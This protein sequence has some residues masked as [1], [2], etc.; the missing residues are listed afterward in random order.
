MAKDKKKL[1][2]T[3]RPEEGSSHEFRQSSTEEDNSRVA[4]SFP[5]TPENATERTGRRSAQT[6]SDIH[7]RAEAPAQRQ[8]ASHGMPEESGQGPRGY[9]RNRHGKES[10]SGR[11]VTTED[12]TANDV[13]DVARISFPA[14]EAES[15]DE[16]RRV[17]PRLPA[18]FAL[19]QFRPSRGEMNALSNVTERSEYGSQTSG[20]GQAESKR[21]ESTL[22]Q[23]IAD[24][25]SGRGKTK[26]QRGAQTQGIEWDPEHEGG[27][28]RFSFDHTPT[29]QETA[30]TSKEPRPERPLR[31][32][33]SSSYA[34]P[35]HASRLKQTEKIEL[36]PSRKTSR[37]V[38]KDP[39]GSALLGRSSSSA[40]GNRSKVSSPREFHHGESAEE[41]SD[42]DSPGPQVATG[43]REGESTSAPEPWQDYVASPRQSPKSM[44][45]SDQSRFEE[46]VLV[47]RWLTEQSSAKKVQL[48]SE[49]QARVEVLKDEA[50]Y[51]E[52]KID[53]LN[54]QPEDGDNNV[55]A[56]K[57]HTVHDGGKNVPHTP[58][59]QETR[60]RIVAEECI[61]VKNALQVQIDDLEEGIVAA[62]RELEMKDDNI[63]AANEYAKEADE[64]ARTWKEDAGKIREEVK[65]VST[66]VGQVIYMM[67]ESTIDLHALEDLT[68]TLD[69]H[70][71]TPSLLSNLL[72]LLQLYER[73]A[74][75]VVLK[76]FDIQQRLAD[77]DHE[78]SMAERV[79]RDEQADTQSETPANRKTTSQV[80]DGDNWKQLFQDK[81]EEFRKYRARTEEYYQRD[82][83]HKNR[84]LRIDLTRAQDENRSLKEQAKKYMAE[85]QSWKSEYNNALVE[86]EKHTAGF[87]DKIKD[88]QDEMLLYIKEYHDKAR[89]PK[90]WELTGLQNRISTLERD[91]HITNEMFNATKSEKAKIEDEV[92]R[93][94]DLNKRNVREIER[95]D[96]GW[97][98]RSIAPSVPDSDLFE[99]SS[100]ISSSSSIPW[101]TSS[102][103]VSH[104]GPYIPR[105]H[106]PKEIGK[107]EVML[108]EFRKEQQK[109]REEEEAG[110]ESMEKVR[111]WK[112]GK[113]YPPEKEDWKEL[114]KMSSW[115]RWDGDEWLD[116]KA[117]R[118]EKLLVG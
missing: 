49:L 78:F 20:S 55:E 65:D 30:L 48:E 27:R 41:Y 84:D 70:H 91:L 112:M 89:D 104:K 57:V 71:E 83:E 17:V 9:A 115:E 114:A 37:D 58:A 28:R 7:V 98:T 76:N 64:L 75:A 40:F 90:H 100:N 6:S 101:L 63:A 12:R 108:K 43:S 44:D 99:T 36:G 81:T 95:I 46:D 39:P 35:T 102:K 15:A 18:G 77:K 103:R 72:L 5:P 53:A 4:T 33:A 50:A 29:E 10:K 51:P 110:Y 42:C 80:D 24:I 68:S 86:S 31:A 87:E 1:D 56:P 38:L 25:L 109:R 82:L 66:A 61:R 45:S 116:T 118:S 47:R 19:S 111:K 106:L 8:S 32:R 16:A 85:A 59:D 60:C 69:S 21:G 88:Q 92:T 11:K 107:R 105:C 3:L 26:E 54:K 22:N 79:R 34:A 73:K 14:V 113:L 23:T 62:D 74:Q 93:L 94:M 67:S 13:E 117:G 97:I 96:R 52:N 2:R